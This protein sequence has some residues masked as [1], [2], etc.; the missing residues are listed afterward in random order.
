MTRDFPDGLAGGPS[1]TALRKKTAPVG[2]VLVAEITFGTKVRGAVKASRRAVRAALREI[3]Y[4][5]EAAVR[6]AA[7]E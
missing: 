4:L 1:R 7:A 6:T 2:A 5:T 3:R